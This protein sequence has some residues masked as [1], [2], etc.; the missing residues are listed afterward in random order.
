MVVLWV[1]VV[2]EASGFR[3]GAACLSFFLQ[4]AISLMLHSVRERHAP[5]KNTTS[6]AT[7]QRTPERPPLP[8][9]TAPTRGTSLILGQIS[10]S[11][12]CRTRESLKDHGF[13]V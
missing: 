3:G 13:I 10:A 9:A 4:P 8:N 11:I 5:R 1:S 2:V 12:I 6:Q 7:G